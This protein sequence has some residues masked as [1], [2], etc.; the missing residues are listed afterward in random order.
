MGWEAHYLFLHFFMAALGLSCGMC[1]SL[2]S[3]GSRVCRLKSCGAGTYLL[4]DL[5]DFSSLTRN[6]TQVT[7]IARQILNHWTTREVP[8]SLPVGPLMDRNLA[9]WS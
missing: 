1:P 9:V 5:W 7:C 8:R 4:R 2:Q 6:Q 3:A